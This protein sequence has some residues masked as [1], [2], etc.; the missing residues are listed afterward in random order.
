MY[1][2]NALS[3]MSN[4]YTFEWA[5]VTIA[6]AKTGAILGSA[7]V[8]SFDPNKL[9]ITQYNNPLV[10]FSYEPGSTMKIFSFMAAIEE[11]FFK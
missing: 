6:N 8:P 3:D 10:S 11:G 9:N 7:T 1:L 4:E 5:N 2:E